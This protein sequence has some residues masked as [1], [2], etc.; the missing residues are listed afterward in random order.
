MGGADAKTD[1]KNLSQVGPLQNA[2]GQVIRWREQRGVLPMPSLHDAE[3]AVLK[4]LM[5]AL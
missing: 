2:V 3:R 1:A 4:R 5:L